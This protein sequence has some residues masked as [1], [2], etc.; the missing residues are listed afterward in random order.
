[1]FKAKLAQIVRR[2]REVVLGERGAVAF[3]LRDARKPAA[4]LRRRALLRVC[5]SLD[6]SCAAR[7]SVIRL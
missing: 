3:I 6:S 5:E 2:D 4:Q 7:L 1:M